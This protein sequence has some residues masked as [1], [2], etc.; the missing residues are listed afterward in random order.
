MIKGLSLIYPVYN[1]EKRV[2][3][4]LK[5]TVNFLKNKFTDPWEIILICNGCTDNTL[6][7][8][9]NFSKIENNIRVES[10]SSRGLGLAIRRGIENAKYGAVMFYAIDLPFGLDIIQESY[11]SLYD[12]GVD[13]LIGS[14]RH[15]KSIN[16]A[17]LKR[18]FFSFILNKLLNFLFDLGIKDAQ[19]S[20]IFLRETALSLLKFCNSDGAFFCTQLIIYGKFSDKKIVEIPVDYSSPR[21]DSK[22]VT[23]DGFSIIRQMVHEYKKISKIK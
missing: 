2:I 23:R 15:A 18:K 8:L 20:L 14:K 16:R 1:E 22:M 10:L 3:E 9:E 17:P 7:L 4:N 6:V 5:K 11:L 19:G 12:L 21:A 13:I